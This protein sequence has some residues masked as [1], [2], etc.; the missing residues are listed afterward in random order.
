MDYLSLLLL[1]CFVWISIQI[2]ISKRLGIKTPRS[3]KL[4]PGPNPFPIIGNIL[5]LSNQPHQ[6]LAKLSQ[7][8]G[9]IM[10]LKLGNITTIVISSPQLAKEVLHKNDLI[11]FYRTVPDTLKALDHHIHSMGWMQ[12]SPLW[13]TL[14][15]VCATKVFSL[16]QL[17]STQIIRQKKLKEL[18]DFVKEKSEKGEILDINEAIFITVL[19]SMSSTLFSMNLVNFGGFKSQ[20]FKEIVCGISEEAAKPNVVDF[21]PIL[22]IFDPQGARARMTKHFRKIINIFDGIVEERLRLRAL[23]E[24]DTKEYKDVLDYLLEVMLEENSQISRIHV[25][26]LLLDLFVA[27]L[28]TTSITIEWAMAELL[29][30]PEKMQKL[31][32]EL[33]HVLGKGE[34]QIEESHISNLPFLGAVVKET[35]RFHTPIPFL[36][37]HKSQEDVE[38]CG[39]TVPKN[40]QVWVNVW[41]MGRDSSIW[42]NPNEFMPERFLESKIDFK[43]QDFEL[44]P[45]G[46]GRRICPG[47]PLAYRTMHIVLG[48]LVHGYDW[49]LV[50]GQKAKDLDMSEN[51]GL[52]LHKA[53]SLQA[54]PIKTQH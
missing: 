49:K 29:R 51:F 42:I 11:F 41:A 13:R 1:A 46:A 23:D 15:K 45:F 19:N 52:T 10:T 36:L 54:I 12:P 38:L 4:P 3:L 28:D 22:R 7:T 2:L 35:L 17:D 8:Y 31:K 40:A 18:A 37:P 48:T 26:H 44:I 16:Q 50:N 25:L 14:R 47:L 32:E 9:P 30:N 27:G 33:E 43:G 20:E 24:M 5:E 39:F 21:F 53:Q 34:K 6:A